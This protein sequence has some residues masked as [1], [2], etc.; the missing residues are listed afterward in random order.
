MKLPVHRWFRYSAGFSAEWVESVIAQEKRGGR[1]AVFDPF[2]GSGTTLVCAE[3]MEVP[4]IGIEAHPFVVR[5]A[6]A[7]L[8]HHVDPAEY[9]RLTRSLADAARAHTGSTER[10]ASLI[11]RCYSA[12]VL[13]ELDQL[14]KAVEAC[15]APGPLLDL[16]WLTLVAILRSVSHVGTAP[17]QYLLPN[18]RKRASTRPLEAFRVMAETVFND[19][20]G[21]ICRGPAAALIQG[22]ARTCA[23]VPDDF[24][25]LVI[26]SPPY[27][28]NYD[29]ADATRLEMTFLG[30]IQSW[31]DLQDAVRKHLVR[32]C[33][34]HVSERTVD[35]DDILSTGAI[36]AIRDELIPICDQLG[37]VRLH[38][39]GKKN[40]H[41]MIGCYFADMALVWQSLR[42][43]CR[44]GSKV[45][46]VI[47]DSAPYGTYV[48]VIE[49]NAALALQAGFR[50]WRFEK[51]R[52]R[53]VK[54]KNRKHRV[55]LREGNLWVEG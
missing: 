41:L 13:T 55:P 18:R 7:K 25:T 49:W 40:Y 36:E 39:G 27:A 26:T 16:A 30:Q 21:Y 29:Y 28:N 50:D 22:D 44:P 52:D 35:L 9:L 14:R 17:W 37:T 42:R 45:C 5:V 3:R 31:A 11:R 10:Y 20:R 2:A 48:P 43:V 46:F 24:A 47:G 6:K 54:W 34:Q 32:S 12:P 1:V 4:S 51:V 38:R 53:N 15:K 8:G 23:G 19:M 33:S